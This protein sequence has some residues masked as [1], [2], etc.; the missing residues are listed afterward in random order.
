MGAG[1]VWGPRGPLRWVSQIISNPWE[2]GPWGFEVPWRSP[3]RA[4]AVAR[5]LGVHGSDQECTG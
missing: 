5:S 4:L 3:L 2:S 1:T